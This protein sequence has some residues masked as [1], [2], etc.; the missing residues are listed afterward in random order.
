MK[1]F[2]SLIKIVGIFSTLDTN[3]FFQF[4]DTTTLKNV[5]VGVASA[6]FS[7]RGDRA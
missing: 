3:N 6:I 5:L 1:Q 2:S 7:L 4:G